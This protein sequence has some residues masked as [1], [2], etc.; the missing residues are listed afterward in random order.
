[1][2][3]DRVRSVAWQ[4]PIGPTTTRSS[5]I[6]GDRAVSADVGGGK[7]SPTASGITHA[8]P[9]D[10]PRKPPTVVTTHGPLAPSNVKLHG[11]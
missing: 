6:R 1:M 3:L 5:N 11:T 4:P 10:Y 2:A 7:D 9:I 8:L